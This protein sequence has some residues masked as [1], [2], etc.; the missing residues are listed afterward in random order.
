MSFHKE[1][2]CEKSV[3]SLTAYVQTPKVDMKHK[4]HAKGWTY[5]NNHKLAALTSY[6]PCGLIMQL[7]LNAASQPKPRLKQTGMYKYVKLSDTEHVGP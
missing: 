3:L 2:S 1:C 6:A 5:K 7:Y 4:L